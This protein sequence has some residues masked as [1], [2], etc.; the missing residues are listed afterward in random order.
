MTANPFFRL[1]AVVAV[2]FATLPSH[3]ED[4]AVPFRTQAQLIVKL[5]GYDR[6]LVARPGPRNVLILRTKATASGRAA[7]AILAELRSFDTIASAAHLDRIAEFTSTT[8][9]R[10]RVLAESIQIL[11]LCPGLE[12]QIPAIANELAGTTLLSIGASA[13]HPNLGAVVGFDVHSGRTQL[14][15]NLRQSQ[16]Q[17][18]RFHAE[19]LKIA[20]VIR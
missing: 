14:L 7:D 17:N 20:K 2:L 10:K 6:S 19:F 11:Y 3:A 8:E 5:A 1:L 16:R 15:V 4:V 13:D 9:L 18:V 12:A